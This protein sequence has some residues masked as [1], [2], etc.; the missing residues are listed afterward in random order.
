MKTVTINRLNLRIN[1]QRILEDF[2]VVQFTQSD[3]YIKFGAQFID[4]FSQNVMARAVVFENG[5][6]LYTLFDKTEFKHIDLR[7]VLDDGTEMDGLKYEIMDKKLLLAIPQ[8]LLTQ[9]LFNS[10]SA[11][12]S[13]R[14]KI[15]NLTGKLFLF[16]ESLFEKRKFGKNRLITKIPAIEVK[17][18]KNF[19][20]ELRTRTFTSLLLL[21]RLKFD[22]KPLKN[23]AKYTYVH[24]TKSMRRILNNEEIEAKDIFILKQEPGKKNIIPF[25]DFNDLDSYLES[26]MGQLSVITESIQ[27]KLIEYL[28]L[29]FEHKKVK[30]S[31]RL[32]V[33]DQKGINQVL[34]DKKLKLNIINSLG[35]EGFEYA[36][37]IEEKLNHLFKQNSISHSDKPNYKALNICIV[38]NKE[39]YQKNNI[40]DSYSI[41][42]AITQHITVEDFNFKSLSAIKALVKELLIKKDVHLG[43]VTLVD[44]TTFNYTSNQIFGIRQD[45]NY[46][47]LTIDPNGAMAFER[48]ELS[49]FNQSEFD[50]LIKIF[51]E[52]KTVEGIIQNDKEEFNIIRR[53][54]LFTLPD[55]QNIYQRLLSEK[56]NEEFKKENI[57]LWLSELDIETSQKNHYYQVITNHPNS[58]ISKT[59]LLKL[60]D[61]RTVKKKLSQ[62]IEL[63]SGKVLKTYMR[64]HSKYELMDSNLDIHSYQ[65]NGN[66]FYYVGTIGNGMRTKITRASVVREISGF[67]L[68]PIFFNEM[69]P[70]MNVDFVRY[71]DLTVVPFPFKYLREWAKS[72]RPYSKVGLQS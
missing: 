64:D 67:H 17:I 7:K 40:D 56:K 24:A 1:H 11:P 30:D 2:V 72:H 44:W 53:S 21:S 8:H 70:L 15:N 43:Q 50:D 33:N 63:K 28:E 18:N 16:K 14:L 69:L 62:I 54:E 59:E 45:D 42:E 27:D 31:V 66:L 25:I 4:E 3:G 68:D 10:L 12:K 20:L 6:S 65:E 47:F 5:S 23:Y 49:L 46:Y 29:S 39:Y 41:G 9:L 22:K 57:Q 36:E 52:D 38:H 61:H 34:L 51:N 13:E 32:N 37:V 58:T 60:I 19:M 71:G 48:K 55:F 35:E 26:K